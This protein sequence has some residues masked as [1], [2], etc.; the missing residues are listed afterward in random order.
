MLSIGEENYKSRVSSEDFEKSLV[1]IC[2]SLGNK[3]QLVNC[4]GC[5][6]SDYSPYG[7]GNI[8]NLY[9]FYNV[10]EK[11]LTVSSKF[12]TLESNYTIFD[13]FE[14]R[15][16]SPVQEVDLCGNFRPRLNTKGGY[17]GQIYNQ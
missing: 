13:A 1:P 17:R 6:Y 14:E 16:H 4:F 8:G 12:A 15:L 3:Y 5:A 2:K 11:Y 9:C 7:G 10:K